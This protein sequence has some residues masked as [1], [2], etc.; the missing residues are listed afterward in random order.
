MIKPYDT[1]KKSSMLNYLEFLIIKASSYSWSSVRA[2][3][4]HIARQIELWRL[5]WTSSDEIRDKAV[6]FFKHSDLRSSQ[7]NANS[8][9]VSFPHQ[10]PFFQQ[11]FSAKSEADKSCRQWNYYGSCACDKSNLEAFNARHRCCVCTK[12]HSML[13][14]PKRRNPIPPPIRRDYMILIFTQC[15]MFQT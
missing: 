4:S 10:A 8:S 14:C 5:E 2:F 12:D 13:Q 1:A 3:H 7:H 6:T 11:H 15:T 9:T